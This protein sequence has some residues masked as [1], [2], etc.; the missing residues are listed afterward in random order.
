MQCRKPRRSSQQS[1][2]NIILEQMTIIQQR[3]LVVPLDQVQPMHHSYDRALLELGVDDV[4]HQGFS[5]AVNT[6]ELLVLF[7]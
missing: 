4:L 3:D 2:G 6:G 1:R 7:A 5:L